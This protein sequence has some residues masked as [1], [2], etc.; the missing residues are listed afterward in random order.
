VNSFGLIA[1]NSTDTNFINDCEVISMNTLMQK[2]KRAIIVNCKLL[3]ITS[4]L[5]LFS[6]IS[7]ATI[8]TTGCAGSSCTLAELANGGF[9]QIDN[10]LLSN[11][12]YQS[13]VSWNPA[14][15]ALLKMD[16]SE[17]DGATSTDPDTIN[18]NLM[19]ANPNVIRATGTSRLAFSY[20][21]Q[22]TDLDSLVTG[23]KGGLRYMAYDGYSDLYIHGTTQV[24]TSAFS[25]NIGQSI[26]IFDWYHIPVPS[27][28]AVPNLN[29]IWITTVLDIKSS[30]YSWNYVQLG[31]EAGSP[32]YSTVITLLPQP[33]PT[34]APLG[35][36]ILGAVLLISVKR[37]NTVAP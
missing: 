27:V 12:S 22:L 9:I 37:E 11:W 21:F 34:P 16:V 14:N 36:I 2:S 13:L 31:Y 4:A 20:T 18:L 1:S 7:E 19:P 24:G 32:A 25:S 5:L 8:T 10:L 30:R 35:L 28:I 3:A 6:P 17:S 29:S 23:V 15:N 26:G 33:A